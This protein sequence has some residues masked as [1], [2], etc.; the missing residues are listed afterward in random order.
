LI[1][2]VS[3][4][5]DAGKAFRDELATAGT[6]VATTDCGIYFS[7]A[8]L[9]IMDSPKSC[10]WIQATQ[11]EVTLG[12]AHTVTKDTVINV[13]SAIIIGTDASFNALCGVPNAAA[14]LTVALPPLSQLKTPT[15]IVNGKEEVGSCRSFRF[16]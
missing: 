5:S 12:N 2:T 6:P 13:R 4:P 16:T 11:L 1:L 8:D 14:A 10:V 7:S 3:T 15:A 9:T